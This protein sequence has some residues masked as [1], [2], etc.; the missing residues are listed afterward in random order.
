MDK[1]GDIDSKK[2][3]GEIAPSYEELISFSIKDFEKLPQSSLNCNDFKERYNLRIKLFG[4]SNFFNEMVN[5]LVLDNTTSKYSYI[6]NT[7]ILNS[8][9]FNP[10]FNINS[11][12]TEIC[13]N[14]SSKILSLDLIENLNSRVNE[15]YYLNSKN[16]F[17][18]SNIIENIGDF[19]K[20]IQRDK[21]F[22][23]DIL[24]NQ[25]AYVLN[26]C[27][28][29]YLI[30]NFN[31]SNKGNGIAQKI[32]FKNVFP[33]NVIIH[34][35]NVFVN[36]IRICEKNIL[37]NG[38]SLLLKLGDLDCGKELNV[39][40]VCGLCCFSNK[41]NFCTIYYVNNCFKDRNKMFLNISQKISNGKSI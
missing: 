1:I 17:T 10:Q 38:N 9:L 23:G 30:C 16:G 32:I 4:G 35:E 21:S 14:N 31:L 13:V 7:G 29:C 18:L 34:P 36:G 33:S 20:L 41:I 39:T 27:G 5:S 15:S 26:R 2:I 11:L 6:Y 24:L 37:L 8:E 22:N 3:Y 40:M 28:K 12:F 25:K 19:N